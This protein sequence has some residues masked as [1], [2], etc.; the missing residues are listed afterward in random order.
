MKI[1]RLVAIVGLF[2]AQTLF[3]QSLPDA[4]T[5]LDHALYAADMTIRALDFK[6]TRD[7]MRSPCR[8][9]TEMDP[10]APHTSAIGPQAAFQ[11]GLSAAVILGSRE[12]AKHHHPRWARA[13]LIVD[14][15]DESIAVGNN[16]Q[17]HSQPVR[18]AP[19]LHQKQVRR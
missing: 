15:V 17:L 12:L 4:P 18:V 19:P 16:L 10:I 8:C 9:F 11:F 5:R 1:V 3:A 14:I 7:F 2:A 6:T 13:L